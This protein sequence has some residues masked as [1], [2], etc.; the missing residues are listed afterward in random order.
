[1]DSSLIR[2]DFLGAPPVT[3]RDEKIF[4]KVIRAAF[5]QRRK[6]IINSVSRAEAFG[7]PKE[8]LAELLKAAG[9]DPASRP[10]SLGLSDFAAIADVL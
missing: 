10:E 6:S 3:V 2:L 4:F 7:I 1:V 5:N 8:R 9:V